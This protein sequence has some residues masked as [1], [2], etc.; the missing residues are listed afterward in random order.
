M[1]AKDLIDR[2]RESLQRQ[3]DEMPKTA[4]EDRHIANAKLLPNR[5]AMLERLPR[6]GVVAEVGVASGDF[7]ADILRLAQPKSLT[8]VDMWGSERYSERMMKS[9][10]DRFSDEVADGRVLIKRGLSTEI[11]VTFEDASLDWVYID[12]DHSYPTTRDELAIFS[13]KVK[14]G[15]VIAGHDYVSGNWAG[16]LPYGVIQ[17][18]HEFCAKEDWEIIYISVEQDVPRSFAI[19]KIAG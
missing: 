19:R 10:A 2:Y 18:V 7:F 16:T 1:L 14:P 4:L 8:L 5:Q 9:V 13:R 6:D 15:G 12:T 17:A 11:G 3:I